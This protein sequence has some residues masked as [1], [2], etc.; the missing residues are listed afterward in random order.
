MEEIQEEVVP[1][2]VDK[3]G[4]VVPTTNSYNGYQVPYWDGHSCPYEEH[5]HGLIFAKS[6]DEYV[7]IVKD[8]FSTVIA[9]SVLDTYLKD[10]PIEE[11]VR[12][13]PLYWAAYAVHH[14]LHDIDVQYP[15]PE[16][17]VEDNDEVSEDMHKQLSQH[18]RIVYKEA[19]SMVI[20]N[21]YNQWLDD[22][23]E[24]KGSALIFHK[25]P[26]DWI[27]HWLSENGKSTAQTRR[28]RHQVQYGKNEISSYERRMNRYEHDKR[29]IKYPPWRDCCDRCKSFRLKH[30]VVAS[31]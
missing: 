5:Q 22:E 24:Y 25:L 10:K 12:H 11:L 1:D 23:N 28:I 19:M 14:K 13:A 15:M 31:V 21:E 8:K 30:G 4:L 27:W 26:E 18:S 16:I 3:Y 17:I 9:E 20:R 2:V 7:A 6:T 29:E